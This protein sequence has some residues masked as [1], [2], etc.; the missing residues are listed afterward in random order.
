MISE[1]GHY[2]MFLGFARQYGDREETDKKWHALLEFEAEVMKNLSTGES[3]H[4]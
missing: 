3:I 2:T 1:A 4:G